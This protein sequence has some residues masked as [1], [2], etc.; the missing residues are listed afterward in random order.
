M[1]ATWTA[2]SRGNIADNYQSDHVADRGNE[3]PPPFGYV[4]APKKPEDPKVHGH[5]PDKE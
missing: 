1:P 4:Q 2:E 3:H 5:P